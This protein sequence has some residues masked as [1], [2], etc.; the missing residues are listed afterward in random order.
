MFGD[1]GHLQ[2]SEG[3]PP[4]NVPSITIEHSRISVSSSEPSAPKIKKK[5]GIL[6]MVAVFSPSFRAGVSFCEPHTRNNEEK[7]SNSASEGRILG[8]LDL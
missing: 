8:V 6:S 4:S 5:V 7:H 2:R 3:I 1:M